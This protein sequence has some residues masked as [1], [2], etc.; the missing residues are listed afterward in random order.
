MASNSRGT[1]PDGPALGSNRDSTRQ[2]NLSTVLRLVHL[3]GGISRAQL[4]RATGLNRSTIAALVTELVALGLA[5][6]KEP[7]HTQQHGRPSI[8]LRP[9]PG[10]LALAVNPDVDAVGV[11]LVSLGGRIVNPVRFHTVRAPS[12]AEVVNIVSAVY[13]GMAAS[14]PAEQRVLGVGVAV[15]G[16]VDP[17]DGRVIEAPQLDWREQPL[18]E[19]LREALGLPVFAANDAVV[20]AR[21]QAAFGAGRDVEDFVYL[22]GGASG[23]GGG[24]VS[25]GRLLHGS[26]GFAGQ[27]GHTLVRTDGAA[28]SCGANGCLE[29]EVAREQLLDAAGLPADQAEDLEERVLE[30]IDAGGDAAQRLRAVVDHQASLLAVALRTLVH[31]L[32]PS[33]IIL[34]GF[35][36]VLARVNPSALED[37]VRVGGARGARE[38]VRIELAPLGADPVLTGAAELAFEP[39]LSDPAG[40]AHA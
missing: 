22:F 31:H 34:G 36:R 4:T 28:C 12:T 3:H 23:I 25:G 10:A 2:H 9:G 29:A 30:L 39:L 11:A 1:R 6:E 20:A 32:N 38:E 24:L 13:S 27:L 15:P 35:L 21:A 16:L 17:A 26:T 14:L 33:L 8:M 5:V 19:Q 7:E 40:F 37:A 18:A